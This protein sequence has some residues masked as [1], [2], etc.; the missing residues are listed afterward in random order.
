L[1]NR[2][3]AVATLFGKSVAE[4]TRVKRQQVSPARRGKS[5]DQDEHH[6]VQVRIEPIEDKNRPGRWTE[7]RQQVDAEDNEKHHDVCHD[8][9]LILPTS[10]RGLDAQLD[11]SHRIT[12]LKARKSNMFRQESES[13]GKLGSFIVMGLLG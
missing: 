2:F 11:S 9:G 8:A 10:H 5:P 3:K 6:C 12:A 1:A 4:P 13:D 7:S